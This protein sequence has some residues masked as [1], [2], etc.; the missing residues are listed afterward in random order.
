[1]IL[2]NIWKLFISFSTHARKRIKKG[3]G[4]SHRIKEMIGPGGLKNGFS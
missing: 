4:S 3:G 2:N 1:M